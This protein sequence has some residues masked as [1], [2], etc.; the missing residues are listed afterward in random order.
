MLNSL[1]VPAGGG[2]VG[3]ASGQ[4]GIAPVRGEAELSLHIH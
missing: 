1:W 3:K 4:H 2:D